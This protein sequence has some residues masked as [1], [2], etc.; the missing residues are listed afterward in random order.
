MEINLWVLESD[1]PD[2]ETPISDR[3]PSADLPEAAERSLLSRW[4]PR[5]LKG[6]GN[7]GPP[8]CGAGDQEN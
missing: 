5:L 2:H 8:P 4:L 3:P 6:S 7:S 1:V